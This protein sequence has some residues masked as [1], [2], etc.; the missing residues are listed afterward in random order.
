MKRSPDPPILDS[1]TLKPIPP[2]AKLVPPKSDSVSLDPRAEMF[3]RQLRAVFK[4]LK[5]LNR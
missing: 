2:K 1:E 5:L 4:V 3:L